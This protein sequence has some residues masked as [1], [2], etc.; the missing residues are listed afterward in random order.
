[1]HFVNT[2]QQQLHAT[3]I[4]DGEPVV[5][6][7]GLLLGSIAT[8]YFNVAPALANQN[9]V[10]MYDLRGHG[11]SSQTNSGYS[12]SSMSDDLA[13]IMDHHQAQKPH[14]V[15]HSYG[16]LIALHYAI[17]NPSRVGK[18]VLIDPPLPASLIEGLHREDSKQVLMDFPDQIKH[19]PFGARRIKKIKNTI[20]SLCNHSQFLEEVKEFKDF[21]LKELGQVESS[22]MAIFGEDSPCAGAAFKVRNGI[23]N[24]KTSFVKGGHFIPLEQPH[25]LTQMIRDFLHG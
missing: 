19:L 5:M 6:L 20:E 25:A 12:V 13:C 4:G 22:T 24:C 21:S 17:H 18:L 1:M 14:L 7:H 11:K 15:G 10:I 23:K 2:P 8:W 16:A 3:S 9:Q